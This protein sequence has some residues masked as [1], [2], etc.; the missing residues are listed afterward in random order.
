[1]RGMWKEGGGIPTYLKRKVSGG[2]TGGREGGKRD[3]LAEVV[4]VGL[5]G[6]SLREPHRCR[7]R[8]PWQRVV[9]AHLTVRV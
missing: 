4:G 2:R 9:P 1:M 7:G 5:A 8:Q 3:L 6:L